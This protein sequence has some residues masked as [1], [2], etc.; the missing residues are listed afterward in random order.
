MEEAKIIEKGTFLIGPNLLPWLSDQ[1]LF[2][3]AVFLLLACSLYY[4]AKKPIKTG[5]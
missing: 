2:A 3:V 1:P 5:L 4:Y